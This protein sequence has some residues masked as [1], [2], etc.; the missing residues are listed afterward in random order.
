M[1]SNNLDLSLIIPCYNEEEV[2]ELFI[3]EIYKV[4]DALNKS[5]E[6]IFVNDGSTDSTFKKLIH[7][8]EAHKDIRVINLSRNFG[9]E[10]AMTA[11][12]DLALGEVIIP[13]D[14]DLQ[15]LPD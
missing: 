6:I 13:I 7:F 10:A 1:H 3:Q 12:L 8:K 5:Y 11:G 15:D 14:V 9:K 2:L 4:L